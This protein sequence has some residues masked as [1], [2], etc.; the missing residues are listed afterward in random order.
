MAGP[1]TAAFATLV[2][3]ALALGGTTRSSGPVS[4][5]FGGPI[6]VHVEHVGHIELDLEPGGAA[7]LR[8]VPCAG[9]SSLRATCFVAR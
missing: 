6:A 7:G 4:G 5:P 2:A 8:R 1:S 9:V 3:V